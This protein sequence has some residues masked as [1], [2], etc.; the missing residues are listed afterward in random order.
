MFFYDDVMDRNFGMYPNFVYKA[1]LR[2]GLGGV[3]YD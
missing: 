2:V 1:L 3:N